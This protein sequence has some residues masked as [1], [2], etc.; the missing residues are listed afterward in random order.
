MN[1]AV[2]CFGSTQYI[3][4]IIYSK[5]TISKGFYIFTTTYFPKRRNL[6]SHFIKSIVCFILELGLRC[7][8]GP[9]SKCAVK[10]LKLAESIVHAEATNRKKLKKYI[11]YNCESGG[12]YKAGEYNKIGYDRL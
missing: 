7:T 2:R 12:R 11:P 6:L 4:Q 1:G 5:Q 8:L 9:F 3:H 10:N